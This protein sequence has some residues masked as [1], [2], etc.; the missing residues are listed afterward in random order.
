MGIVPAN[1]GP[2]LTSLETDFAAEVLRNVLK[3]GWSV[4]TLAAGIA[5]VFSDQTG[6][7]ALGGATWSANSL[8][9]F[10][11]GSAV[12]P[13]AT[14]TAFGDL[15]IA[16]GLAAAFDGN[17]SKADAA[18]ARG[19]ALMSPRAIGKRW[20]SAKKIVAYTVTSSNNEGFNYGGDRSVQLDFQGSNDGSS[21]TTLDTQTFTDATATVTKTQ[22]GSLN[23]SASYLYHQVKLSV[24]GMTGGEYICVAQ[25]VFTEASTSGAAVTTVSAAFAA[26]INITQMRLVSLIEGFSFAWTDCMFDVTSDNGVT[27]TPVPLTWLGKYSTPVQIVGGLVGVPLGNYPAWRWR[28]SSFVLKNHGV[29]LQWK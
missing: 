27:W 5:D 1:L 8:T 15:L 6:I 2:R 9:N 3:D 11:G 24:A 13:G 21:W 29:F 26:A 16:G 23:T 17:V 4:C 12:V 7:S 18:C 25:L 22:T 14:G 20:P 19:L 28:T 10:T